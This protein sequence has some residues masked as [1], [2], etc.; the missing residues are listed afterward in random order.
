[1]KKGFMKVCSMMLCSVLVLGLAACGGKDDSEGESGKTADSAKEEGKTTITVLRQDDGNGAMDGLIEAFEEKF[2]QYEINWEKG[3]NET[4]QMRD[5]LNTAFAA[6][7]DEIDVF[8]A[9][10]CWVGEMA[11][12]GYL[13]AL[14]SYIMDSGHTLDEFNPGSITAGTYQA[15]TYALPLYVDVAVMYYRKD[16][17][18]E[19]DAA[20]LESGNYTWDEMI[21]IAEK[22]AGQGGTKTGLTGQF[23]QYEGLM[24]AMPEWT[25]EFK[26]IRGGLETMKKLTDSSATPDDILVYRE[27]NAANSLVNG[28]TVFSRNWPYVWGLMDGTTTVSHD[29]IGVA[30]LPQGSTVGGWMFSMNVN[31]KVKEGAWEFLNFAAAEEGQKIFCSTG[32]YIPGFMALS[33]DKEILDSMEILAMPGLQ[34]DIENAKARP[35]VPQYTEMSDAIQIAV[36]SYLSGNSSLDDAAAEVEKALKDQGV[37]F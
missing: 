21:G 4:D 18:S 8:A 26:D 19:E 24:T 6:G 1:M 32:G 7:S 36:H 17:V 35:S 28:D 13:E 29:Q 2:P 3:S 37:E 16:I 34:K 22:Y 15:K 9:D 31:S 27:E 20:K 30:P 23:G 11:A 25:N 5:Q 33:N 12:A 10:V 14:D